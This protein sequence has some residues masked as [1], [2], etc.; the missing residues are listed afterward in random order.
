[1]VIYYNHEQVESSVS[2]AREVD[3]RLDGL[4]VVQLGLDEAP[5]GIREH[6][7]QLGM[8]VV[9]GIVLPPALGVEGILGLVRCRH[10]WREEGFLRKRHISVSLKKA[11]GPVDGKWPGGRKQNT[12][13]V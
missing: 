5:G 11:R 2:A 13:Y 12:T 10:Y 1:M 9:S 6:A 7:L 3:V 8:A 4:G